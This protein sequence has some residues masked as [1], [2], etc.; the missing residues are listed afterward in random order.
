LITDSLLELPKK[1]S[2]EVIR[3][4]GAILTEMQ[5]IFGRENSKEYFKLIDVHY[6]EGLEAVVQRWIE[7][8]NLSKLYK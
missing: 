3:E 4:K 2:A 5:D 1:E 8:S 6:K 7:Q